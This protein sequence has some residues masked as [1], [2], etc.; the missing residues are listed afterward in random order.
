MITVE[1]DKAD[2]RRVYSALGKIGNDAPKVICRGINKTA[3]VNDVRRSYNPRR[4][5]SE[6]RLHGNAGS[7]RRSTEGMSGIR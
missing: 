5:N 2:L 7:A 4:S 6:Y 3:R 1:V